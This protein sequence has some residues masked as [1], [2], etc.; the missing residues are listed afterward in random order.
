MAEQYKKLIA[1]RN[2]TSRDEDDEININ[3]ISL[4]DLT[5]S[6]IDINKDCLTLELQNNFDAATR[7]KS[8]L[9]EHI[10]LSKLFMKRLAVIQKEIKETYRS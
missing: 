6:I 8:K 1:A 9:R 10:K 3:T 7:A 2:V 5:Q 4:N